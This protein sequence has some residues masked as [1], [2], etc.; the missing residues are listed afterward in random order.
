M[1]LL[2]RNSTSLYG[3]LWLLAYSISIQAVWVVRRPLLSFTSILNIKIDLNGKM[4]K[5]MGSVSEMTCKGKV[6]PVRN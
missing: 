6:V 3:C 5:E 1:L 2:F 4:E